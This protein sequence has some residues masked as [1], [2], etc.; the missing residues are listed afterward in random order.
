[1]NVSENF[2]AMVWDSADNVDPNGEAWTYNNLNQLISRPGYVYSYDEGG[3]LV[4]RS[5][6]GEALF[7]TYDSSNRLTMVTDGVGT[8]VAEYAYDPFG[9]RIYKKV[10]E[11]YTYY[12]YN[13]SGLASE[14]NAE[15]AAIRSYGVAPDA[16]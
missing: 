5:G 14:L 11:H 10:A 9:R 6:N 8:V 3:S 12:L 13:L 4:E 2:R 7:F 15:G 16:E 1:A